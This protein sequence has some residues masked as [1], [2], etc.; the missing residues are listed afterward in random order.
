MCD[1]SFDGKIK[2]SDISPASTNDLKNVE[3]P[4]ENSLSSPLPKKS[5]VSKLYQF[6]IL[7][8]KAILSCIALITALSIIIGIIS[9][10][11]KK[12][13]TAN[14]GLTYLKNGNLYTYQFKEKKQKQL[15]VNLDD[16]SINSSEDNKIAATDYSTIIKFS[17][18][19]RFVL[20]PDKEYN[21]DLELYCKDLKKDKTYKIDYDVSQY[22]DFG[23][24][25]NIYYIRQD[26]SKSLYVHNLNE[27]QHQKLESGINWFVM[28]EYKNKIFISGDMQCYFANLSESSS[29]TK[30]Y[31]NDECPIVNKVSNDLSKI[32]ISDSQGVYLYDSNTASYT[33]V[34]SLDSSK[35]ARLQN[36]L[37]N[38]DGT[39]YYIL[40]RYENIPLEKFF[41]DDYKESDLLLKEPMRENESNSTDVNNEYHNKASAYRDKIQ[42]D[43]NREKLKDQYISVKYCDLKYY[44]GNEIYTL[45]ADRASINIITSSEKNA[46][47]IF[48]ISLNC[49]EL[50]VFDINDIGY[51]SVDKIRQRC[52][53]IISDLE[54]YGHKTTC[55]VADG[56]IG[57]LN[58]SD[59]SNFLVESETTVRCIYNHE[60]SQAF[61]YIKVRNDIGNNSYKVT[62][63]YQEPSQINDN[64]KYECDFNISVWSWNGEMQNNVEVEY[65]YENNGLKDDELAVD[66][67]N[68]QN[69]Q[70]KTY[71][72]L[73]DE[74]HY[75]TSM[76]VSEGAMARG[77]Y[78]RV[79]NN[80]VIAYGSYC[81]F[82]TD[83]R[84]KDI[85]TG[86]LNIIDFSDVPISAEHPLKKE[87]IGQNVYSYQILENNKIIYLSDYNQDTKTG[88]L[89]YYNGS[90]SI[91]IDTEVT[92]IIPRYTKK[93]NSF[94]NFYCCDLYSYNAYGIYSD[95][96]TLK[97]C[98]E[99]ND[100]YPFAIYMYADDISA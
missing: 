25:G 91:L 26:E 79:Y 59:I 21:S 23:A 16:I 1:K 32:V 44:D 63:D 62:D 65:V 29:L 80:S 7:N 98:E 49:N 14:D 35:G 58:E 8:S 60:K 71:G 50:S 52:Y 46:I 53:D 45:F 57:I 95:S 48:D 73:N 94:D 83:I 40:T 67:Y 99:Y 47:S 20:Y 9:L 37:L 88:N 18:D 3:L 64:G 81:A 11:K 30:I 4:I 10:I 6:Y 93:A 43:E 36:V 86:T 12:P 77:V 87:E 68:L 34:F 41:R 56:K 22:Y 78:D 82:L 89:Y 76:K 31:T 54:T 74:K 84:T 92:N 27:N 42:R 28:N 69:F 13:P 75:E 33:E 38:E 72:G 5:M 85:I 15:T 66:F 61:G 39:S 2:N 100:F 19:G 55:I 17:N 70:I 90:K 97:Y 96:Y 24:D 51:S